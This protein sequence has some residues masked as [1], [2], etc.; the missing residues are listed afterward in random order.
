MR[1]EY[2]IDIVCVRADL[3]APDGPAKIVD[4]ARSHFSGTRS[5]P[6][7]ID[8]VVNNAGVCPALLIPDCTSAEFDYTYKVNVLAPLLLM[9]MTLPH[10]PHDRSGRI[11][12][13]SSISANVGTPGQSI[14][15]G[16][17]AAL[18][19]MTRTWAREL[20]ERATVNSLHPGAVLTDMVPVP[21]VA[22]HVGQINRVCPL[23]R[24]REAVDTTEMLAVAKSIGGRVA[25]DYE[26]SEVVAHFAMPEVGWVTGHVIGVDGGYDFIH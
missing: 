12:N 23:A 26:I 10:L 9:Q 18:D 8:I 4:S 5:R 6:F 16:T 3:A 11:I 20:A 17:K 15:G 7:R 1:S 14:Y 21:F 13:I 25:Y 2:G 19:A 22:E 24:P